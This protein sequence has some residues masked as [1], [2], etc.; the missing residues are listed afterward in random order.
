MLIEFRVQNFRSFKDE[1]VLSMVASTDKNLSANNTITTE[2]SNPSVLLR[3]ASI[4]GANASGKSNLIL[5][6]DFFTLM[7]RNSITHQPG[8]LIRHQP[9]KLDIDS[10][11]SATGFE[12]SALISGTKYRY[13]FEFNSERIISEWLY[14]TPKNKIQKWF[15]RTLTENK[16]N[17]EFG[18]FFTGQKK[19]WQDATRPNVL[20]LATAIQLNSEQLR[21]LYDWI[22]QSIITL[23]H[24]KISHQY[25][26]NSLNDLKVNNQITAMM[27]SADFAITNI[28]TTKRK[29]HELAVEIGQ[30][31]YSHQL[32]EREELF[33]VFS[34]KAGELEVNFDFIE[35]ESSG[36]KE[37]FCFAAPLLDIIKNGRCLII[38]ELGRDLHPL[39]VHKII[40]IFHSPSNNKG[41]QLIFTSHDSSL[42]DNNLMRRD[43]IWLTEKLHDHTS[44]L[45]PLL[46]FSP[47]KGEALEKGYLSGRYGGIPILNSNIFPTN[48]DDQ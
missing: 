23:P 31:G 33:P 18:S 11:T 5:A 15:E 19:I 25:S 34:H 9:F 17:Y 48:N 3:S 44:S 6:L 13:G 1:T 39:L 36:T 45:V 47:R 28:S 8:Q 30:Q 35:E 40:E 7:V 16:D 10:T 4:H 38:D 24:G 12:I 22:T 43:Q 41:A 26:T 37:F 27:K 14:A 20:F 42:L 2:I 32:N 46:D 21:P 29:A